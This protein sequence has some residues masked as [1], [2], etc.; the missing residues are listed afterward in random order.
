ML[1]DRKLFSESVKVPNLSARSPV[2]L[3]DKE[4]YFEK[5]SKAI[6]ESEESGRET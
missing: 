6:D 2:K 1:N 5:G 3:I 4:D